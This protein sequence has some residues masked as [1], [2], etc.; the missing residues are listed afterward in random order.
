MNNLHFRLVLSKGCLH[1]ELTLVPNLWNSINEN[2]VELF[3][4]SVIN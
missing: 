2:D 4:Q 3:K 1:I